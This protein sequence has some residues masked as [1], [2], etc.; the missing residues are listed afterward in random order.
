MK[1]LLLL[2]ITALF[3]TSCSS[4]EQKDSPIVKA[5]GPGA[6]CVE[7][8]C[9]EGQGTVKFPQGLE[10][11]GDFKESKV[12]GKGLMMWPSGSKYDGEFNQ[13][14]RDGKGTYTYNN[15]DVYTGDFK[16]N[17]N[18]DQGE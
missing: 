6:T 12:N 18:H 11:K 8:D 7:G 15:G 16:N 17:K 4:T 14:M 3:F 10:Y 5:Y 13:N 9:L 2:G 1:K